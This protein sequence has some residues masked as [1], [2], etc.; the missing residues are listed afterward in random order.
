VSDFRLPPLR[1]V[2]EVFPLLGFMQRRFIVTDVSGQLIG[3]IFRGLSSPRRILRNIPEE[4]RPQTTVLYDL[5]YELAGR[6]SLCETDSCIII[7]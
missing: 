4:Q 3:P 7:L 6:C 5:L 1:G 2:N